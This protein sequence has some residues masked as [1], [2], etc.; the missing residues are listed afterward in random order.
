MQREQREVDNRMMLT[1]LTVR[2]FYQGKNLSEEVEESR[3]KIFV[4]TTKVSVLKSIRIQSSQF[5]FR[6]QNLRRRDQ[7][8]TFLL[9]IGPPVCKR[10]NES[11]SKT[12]RIRH[13]SGGFSSSVNL[14]STADKMKLS[15][16]A[17]TRLHCLQT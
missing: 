2:E 9:R 3:R 14:V 15:K 8:G 1:S 10:Q 5:K 6:I 11:D 7:T 12:F 13:E 17:Y 4:H 16:P